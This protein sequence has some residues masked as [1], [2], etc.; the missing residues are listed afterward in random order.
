MKKRFGIVTLQIPGGSRI[1]K[2]MKKDLVFSPHVTRIMDGLGYCNGELLVSLFRQPV[3]CKLNLSS[4]HSTSTQV[5]MFTT[6]KVVK[7]KLI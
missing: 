7:V 2:R 5:Y 6:M 3:M 4:Y 1:G